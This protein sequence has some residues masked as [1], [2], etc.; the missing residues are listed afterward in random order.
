M[1]VNFA[2]QQYYDEAKRLSCDPVECQNSPDGRNPI[3]KFV[4]KIHRHIDHTKY[5]STP[6]S[7]SFLGQRT[8]HNLDLDHQMSPSLAI[9]KTG[10]YNRMRTLDKS[11]CYASPG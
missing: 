9:I 10:R 5:K 8:L 3:Y 2:S 11:L 4:P 6:F 1:T 7:I